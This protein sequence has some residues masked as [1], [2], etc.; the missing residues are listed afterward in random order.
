MD[1]RS[2][3]NLRSWIVVGC[4]VAV[5]LLADLGGSRLWDRDEPRNARCAVEMLERGDWIVPTFA[6]ELRTH[7]PPLLYWMQIICYRVFGVN[8][9]AARL[10]SALCGLGTVLLTMS[11]A[12]VLMGPRSVPWVG[13]ALGTSLMFVLASR[14]ATPDGALIFASTLAIAIYVRSSHVCGVGRRGERTLLYREPNRWEWFAV[15]CACG[16]AMLAKGPIGLLLPGCVIGLHC[17]WHRHQGLRHIEAVDRRANLFMRGRRALG[18]GI[19]TVGLAFATAWRMR[20]LLAIAAIALIAGPWYAMVG[21]RTDGVWLREF[22]LEHN[23]SRALTPMEGHS[24]PPLLFYLATL[25][26]GTF[27]WSMFAIPVGIA[28]RESYRDH[29]EVRSALVLAIGWVAVYLGFFSVAAT[30]LPSYITPC[31]PGVALMIGWFLQQVAEN[32]FDRPRWLRAGFFVGGIV[33]IGIAIILAGPATNFVPTASV[34]GF[35]GII[36]AVASCIGGGLCMDKKPGLGI[37]TFVVGGVLT[38]GLLFTAGPRLADQHRHELS[39]LSE[40]LHSRTRDDLCIVGNVEPSWIYYAGG[41]I[42]SLPADDS[43]SW[44]P[45]IG[46]HLQSPGDPIAFVPDSHLPRLSTYIEN[47]LGSDVLHISGRAGSFL[48]KD[49]WVAV[50]LGKRTSPRITANITRQGGQR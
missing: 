5:V 17:M 14:A 22:F 47:Q 29:P 2:N 42:R 33:G 43:G 19:S 12:S 6:N 9:T 7:K 18:F 36:L 10:P 15:Y 38:I 37:R 48:T 21:L 31:Y 23:V 40:Q 44:L 46:K 20:P 13:I 41:P 49:A 4:I 45:R 24:G 30:K 28:V 16:L 26:V 3:E 27:P 25:L 50:Q 34:A 32:R 35:A 39:L 8:E 1:Y 11:I